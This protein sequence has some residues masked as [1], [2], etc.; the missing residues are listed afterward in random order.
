MAEIEEGGIV[1]QK[2]YK[3]RGCEFNNITITNHFDKMLI[4]LESF[5]NI[6]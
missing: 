6:F 2:N 4:I 1:K 5:F 3:E